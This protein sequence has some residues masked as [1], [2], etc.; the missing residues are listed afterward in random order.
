[1]GKK[2]YLNGTDIILLATSGMEPG[3]REGGPGLAGSSLNKWGQKN[4]DARKNKDN[5]NKGLQS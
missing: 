3:C 1:M 2:Y 4:A 5:K